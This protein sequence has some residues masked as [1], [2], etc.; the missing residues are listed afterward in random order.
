ME[1]KKSSEGINY[2]RFLKNTPIGEDKFE[3]QSQERIANSIVKILKDERH[4]IIG[5]D[6]GW[7]TGKSNLVKIVEKKIKEDTPDNLYFFTYDAWGHQEDEPRRTILEELTGALVRDLSSF[8][9]G[10]WPEKK[11]K[12]LAKSRER[13]TTTKP[14]LSLGFIIAFLAVVLTP[15]LNV[16][17]DSVH[18][19]WIRIPI[20]SIPIIAILCYYCYKY[21]SLSK[22]IDDN[23]IERKLT[24]KEKLRL[25][26]EKTFE[27]YHQDQIKNTTYETLIDEIPSVTKFRKW[28][29]GISENLNDKKLVL[30][31]DNFD[32]LPTPKVKA[33]WASIHT[34]FS[35]DNDYK[36][37]KVI[38]PFDRAHINSA[39]RDNDITELNRINN[40]VNNKICYGNDFINKTFDVVFR[41]SLPVL[42]DW[43]KY[44]QENWEFAF[45][46]LN[47]D[48]DTEYRKVFQIF[49]RLSKRITPREIIAFINEIVTMRI[50]LDEEIPERYLALFIKGKE[51]ILSETV[52]EIAS[53][54]YLGPLENIYLTDKD[55][56][57]YIAAITY[58]VNSSKALDVVFNKELKD[59]LDSGNPNKVRII[60][61][62]KIFSLLL[63]GVIN[64][65][66]NIENTVLTLS[67]ESF[68]DKATVAISQFWDD[69][70]NREISIPKPGIILK[71]YQKILLQKISQFKRKDYLVFLINLFYDAEKFNALEFVR[72]IKTLSELSRSFDIDIFELLTKKE[73][74]VDNF[75]QYISYERYHPRY[76]VFCNEEEL[77]NTLSTLNTKELGKVDYLK[78]VLKE[79]NNLNK[80]S[81][82]LYS[83]LPNSEGN[84]L[85]IILSRLKD[86]DRRIEFENH[87]SDDVIFRKFSSTPK[88]QNPFYDLLAMRIGR[89]SSFSYSDLNH[90]L[91]TIND[92]AIEIIAKALPYYASL[93]TILLGIFE[94][95]SYPS[96]KKIVYYLFHNNI[97]IYDANILSILPYFEKICE[98]GDIEANELLDMLNDWGEPEIET[99]EVNKIIPSYL[100][101][102]TMNNKNDLATF[103]RQ[104]TLEY[105]SSLDYETWLSKFKETI[106]YEVN[107]AI[108]LKFKWN[109]SA[110]EAIKDTLTQI[111]QEAISIPDKSIWSDIIK[112]VRYK[113][114]LF[115]SILDTILGRPNDITPKLFLFF[116]DWLFDYVRLNK[117]QEVLRK[118][119][120][121][122]VLNNAECLDLIVEKKE[123][124]PDIINNSGEDGSYFED[125]I[126]ELVGNGSEPAI[127]LADYLQFEK[128]INKDEGDQTE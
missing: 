70:Y 52:K 53:P 72:N 84:E 23:G 61:E 88:R 55:L 12:L 38:I 49:E 41:I 15:I 32:R 116:A 47:K 4:Q 124:M 95:T 68:S 123:K 36:N 69:I 91:K 48:S 97:T 117:R 5:I 94:F 2:P 63:N 62:S 22:I 99:A 109:T 111:A 110:I 105:L 66:T 19:L 20:M 92:D 113:S 107:V 115:N 81:N 34:F 3:G 125:I 100:L 28:M 86:F 112:K 108:L 102:Q 101:E 114:T 71:D 24:R 73:T 74:S 16:V 87:L 93:E 18:N 59:A 64:E 40:E 120:P 27:F 77:D 85:Y 37:I 51:Q 39:F 33:L 83:M 26:L 13:N 1:A 60:S 29:K 119:F 9:T 103:L 10:D 80:Y 42:S 127:E 17:T 82:H 8:K 104:K 78:P 31:F 76:K 90:H 35:E 6:G 25:A 46:K 122:S 126:L 89:G 128:K 11:K 98:Q 43:E 44:F 118:L 45:G 54:S 21:C 121:G 96:Y 79:Y 106:I 56:P 67:D 7:G 30:V 57:K 14:S 75:I 65:V 50:S 58:Q